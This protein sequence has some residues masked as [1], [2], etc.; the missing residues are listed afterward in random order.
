[1][2]GSFSAILPLGQGISYSIPFH[3]TYKED[4]H[5]LISCQVSV[6]YSYSGLRREYRTTTCS[7]GLILIVHCPHKKCTKTEY[8]ILK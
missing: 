8:I 5:H 3:V 1:M 4:H 2:D 7:G 6:P